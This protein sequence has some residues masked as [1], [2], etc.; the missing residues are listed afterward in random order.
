M[1]DLEV[2]KLG[3]RNL[4]TGSFWLPTSYFISLTDEVRPY[5]IIQFEGSNLVS[6]NGEI[7][8]LE[9]KTAGCEITSSQ[10]PSLPNASFVVGHAFVQLPP[11]RH[12]K[13]D[14]TSCI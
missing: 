13:L 6:W 11:R 1:M 9:P 12:L 5:T 14:P 2:G 4:T 8:G 10:L 3:L 7:A